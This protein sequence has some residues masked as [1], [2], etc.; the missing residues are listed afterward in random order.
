MW[1]PPPP[2]MIARYLNAPLSYINI[3]KNSTSCC[4]LM[5]LGCWKVPI[6][7]L[8]V[9]FF[10]INPCP[11]AI[12]CKYLPYVPTCFSP[13]NNFMKS[14]VTI[15]ETQPQYWVYLA[16]A[17]IATILSLSLY[18]LT[19]SWLNEIVFLST[20]TLRLQLMYRKFCKSIAW[21][22][23]N[24]TTVLHKGYSFMTQRY[25][26]TTLG[27]FIYDT[28]LQLYYIRGCSF[29]TQCYNCTLGAVHV[30]HN[31]RTVVH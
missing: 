19:E 20:S 24:A 29:M 18:D 11:P 21:L 1:P 13:D 26:C 15:P 23:D 4:L 31:A 8:G 10:S 22:W 2:F 7:W 12:L 16:V 6:L 3:T 28:I 17:I 14:L 9:W 5:M 25:N 30:W 27:L